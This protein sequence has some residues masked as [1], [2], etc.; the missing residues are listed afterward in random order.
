LVLHNALVNHARP[1]IGKLAQAIVGVDETLH[2]Y[3]G[4]FGVLFWAFVISI[5]SQLTLPISAWLSGRALGIPAPLSSYLAYIPIAVIAASL[6]VSPNGI[7]ILDVIIKHFFADRGTA[8]VSQTFALTQ[9]VRFL[10]IL[11]NLVGA[12]WVMT[13]KYTRRSDFSGNQGKGEEQMHE[14]AKALGSG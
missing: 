6:P 10:P 11:W 13:G 7:G 12:Y 4:H 3:R 2:V 1:V 9:A 5:I 14:D 8:S